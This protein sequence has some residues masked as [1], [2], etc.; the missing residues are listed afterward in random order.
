MD[1][2]RQTMYEPKQSVPVLLPVAL[3]YY[4]LQFWIPG[5]KLWNLINHIQHNDWYAQN[6]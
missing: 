1:K 6:Y 3:C 4:K 2:L 5:F